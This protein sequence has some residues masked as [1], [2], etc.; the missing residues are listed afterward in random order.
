MFV[1]GENGLRYSGFLGVVGLLLL[2]NDAAGFFG[3]FAG[4]RLTDSL[5]FGILILV[6]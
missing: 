6:P 2:R 4:K 3:L 5:R 1:P